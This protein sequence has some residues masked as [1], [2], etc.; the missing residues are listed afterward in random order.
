MKR[1]ILFSIALSMLFTVNTFAADQAFTASITIRPAVEITLLRSLTFGDHITSSAD[2]DVVI[3]A[4]DNSNAAAFTVTGDATAVF[5]FT[6]ST[7]LMTGLGDDI[8]VVLSL[9]DS[10]FDLSASD[11]S[12]YVGGTATIN[13][14]QLAGDY[15]ATANLNAVYN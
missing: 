8:S 3:A 12:I 15:T 2:Q 1:I 13:A 7:I 6:S 4:T 10:T 9:S 11:A 5:T 14:N